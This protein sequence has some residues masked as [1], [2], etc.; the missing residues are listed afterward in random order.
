[1]NIDVEDLLC[2]AMQR[3]AADLRVPDGLAR[4]VARRPR[5][6]LA[7]RSAATVAA[8][9]AAGAVAVA[10]A[11]V[12][13]AR[14]D[15]TGAAAVTAADVVRR[16]DSALS[17]AGP[18]QVAQMTVTTRRTAVPGAATATI[19]SEVWSYGGQWRL[20]TN[21]P[22]GQSEYEVGFSASSVCTLVSYQTR[23]WARQ[24]GPGSPAVQSPRDRDLSSCDSVAAAIPELFPSGARDIFAATGSPPATVAAA[25]RTAV[26]GG[27][28][29]VAGQQRMDGIDAI[30]L[31][32]LP[33]SR[34]VETIWVSP[35]TYLPVQVA[36]GPAPGHSGPTQTADIS[37]L[38]PTTQ[39][40]ARLTVTIPAGFRQVPFAQAVPPGLAADPGRAASAGPGG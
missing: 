15:G 4:R 39:Y 1:M 35:A 12:P 14:H 21:W 10:L 17:A 3:L 40:Q 6:R 32:S 13:G 2:E 8:V 11:G 24:R 34:L 20:V 23:V 9:L 26:S 22:A 36:A 33:D 29:A 38:P 28:L 37:W 25:L 27:T 5:R 31:T 18:G 16:V 7:L 19:T 30:K